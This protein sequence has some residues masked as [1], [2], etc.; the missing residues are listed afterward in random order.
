M[1]FVDRSNALVAGM[2]IA[3]KRKGSEPTFCQVC[4]VPRGAAVA[5]WR[6]CDTSRD[7]VRASLSSRTL[8]LSA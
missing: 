8:G 6:N 2:M 3:K 7:G 4:G 1:P 5:I